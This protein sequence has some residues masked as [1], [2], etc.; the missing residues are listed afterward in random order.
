MWVL[1]Q[2]LG[3]QDHPVYNKSD[4]TDLNQYFNRDQFL[5]QFSCKLICS[6]GDQVKQDICAKC[7]L[8]ERTNC[9]KKVQ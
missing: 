4:W 1:G 9:K 2:T 7:A 6:K 8:S 5:Q 3:L